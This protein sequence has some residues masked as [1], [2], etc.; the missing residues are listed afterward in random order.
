MFRGGFQPGVAAHETRIPH[1]ADVTKDRSMNNDLLLDSG[2]ARWRMRQPWPADMDE[3]V[4]L[5]K[6][7]LAELLGSFRRGEITSLDGVESASSKAIM[8]NCAILRV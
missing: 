4:A 5:K 1:A 2:F 7:A 6:E 3:E 8:A